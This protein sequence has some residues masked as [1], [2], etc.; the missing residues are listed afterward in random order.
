MN[1][2]WIY[3]ALTS[4][5]ELVWIFGFN[6]ANQW[7]HWIFIVGFIFVDFHFLTKACERLPTG[8]VYAVFAGIGTVGTSLMDV[9]FFGEHI[10][11]GKIFFI[12]LLVIGVAGLKIADGLDEKKASKGVEK[13]GMATGVLGSSK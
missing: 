10:S 6:T 12:F 4:F 3:V 11:L 2:A 5:F 7:W 1:K 9:L 8:T 13:D